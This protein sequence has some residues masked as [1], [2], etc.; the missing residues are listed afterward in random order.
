MFT[1]SGEAFVNN[2]GNQ[3]LAKF[4]SGDVLTGIIA[5]VA[6]QKTNPRFANMDLGVAVLASI[7]LHGFAGDLLREKS[8]EYGFT[9]TDIIKI[10]PKAIK[11]LVKE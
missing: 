4:G 1:P 2:V 9:A 11:K 7:Y 5:G 3:G 10:L 6:A 8:T